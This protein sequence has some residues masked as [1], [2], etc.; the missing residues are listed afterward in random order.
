MVSD[1]VRWGFKLSF[2]LALPVDCLPSIMEDMQELRLRDRISQAYVD[3]STS[4]GSRQQLEKHFIR[5]W[6]QKLRKP[7]DPEGA[8]DRMLTRVN[9][10]PESRSRGETGELPKKPRRR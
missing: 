9:K 1:A 8:T 5:S 6:R 4:Q 2:L 7:L 3:L 10:R